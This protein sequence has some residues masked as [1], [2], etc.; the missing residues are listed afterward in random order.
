MAGFSSTFIVE[1]HGVLR[2]CKNRLGPHDLGGGDFR[3]SSVVT[4]FTGR[5]GNGYG[6]LGP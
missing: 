3:H 5:K 1:D 6:H 2:P 4:S